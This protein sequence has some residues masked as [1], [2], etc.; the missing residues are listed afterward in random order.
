M[1]G[2]Q[3]YRNLAK[4]MTIVFSFDIILDKIFSLD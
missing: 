4:L 1:D 2:L 3:N